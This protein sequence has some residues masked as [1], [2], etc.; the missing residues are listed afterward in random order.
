MNIEHLPRNRKLKKFS[1]SLRKNATPEENHLWY[2][3]LRTYPIQFKRQ[4]IIGS[5]IADFYCDQAKL[6]I[7]LDGEQHYL[8]DAPEYD[9]ARTAYFESLGITVLRFDNSEI[10]REFEAVCRTIEGVISGE[11]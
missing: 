10:K 8:N 9:A 11:I 5:Y 7:E 1:Q 3:F 2:D 4:F 6:V